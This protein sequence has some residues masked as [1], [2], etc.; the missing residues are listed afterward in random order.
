M[1]AIFGVPASFDN[2][3]RV[4]PMDIP[5]H[6]GGSRLAQDR[7]DDPAASYM[8]TRLAAVAQDVG[9]LTTGLLKSVGQFGHAVERPLIVDRLSYGDDTGRQPGRLN[10]DRAEG[11]AEDVLDEA[12]LDPAFGL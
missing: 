12:H 6:P 9:D 1:W 10:H 8:R 7:I 4:W 3:S 11:V 2:R 5:R